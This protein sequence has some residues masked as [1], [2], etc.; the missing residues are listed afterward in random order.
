MKALRM[1]IINIENHQDL[2][3]YLREQGLITDRDELRCKN[4]YGGVSNRTVKIS[5]SPSKNWVIKQALEK[6]R[7]KEDWFSD[8]QRIHREAEGL[9]WLAELTPPGSVPGFIFED[10]AQHLLIMQAV[11][12]PHQNYKHLLLE[13]EPKNIHTT[14]FARLCADIHCN[15]YDRRDEIASIFADAGFFESLRIDPYYVFSAR[16]LPE[17]AP[18]LFNLIKTTRA[19]KLTLVHGDYSP[20]NILIQNNRLILL[21]HEVIH[22]GDPAFDIGFSLAHLLSKAHYRSSLRSQ[23]T[24]AAHLF[25]QTYFKQTQA[26][27]WADDLEQQCVNHTLGCLLARVAGKSPLE[28]LSSSQRTL[29]KMILLQLIKKHPATMQLLIEQFEERLTSY[30]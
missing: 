15:S 11:A 7:V 12:E 1:A 27:P 21:D 14:T 24:A 28:Y 22:F 29:Q 17:A 6:L 25:W 19:R 16:Q 23:F 20:K 18:F 5:C 13:T 8:P 4:L 2:V 9:R 26:A 10:H 30:G 3:R